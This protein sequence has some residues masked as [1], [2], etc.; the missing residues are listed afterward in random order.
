MNANG[1]SNDS[2]DQDMTVEE[3]QDVSLQN[4]LNRYDY[5]AFLPHL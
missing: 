5:K 1:E 3:D 4:Y 2:V